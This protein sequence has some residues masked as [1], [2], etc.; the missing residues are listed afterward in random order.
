MKNLRL[1][2]W[3]NGLWPN[4]I[5]PIRYLLPYNKRFHN[6]AV[7]HDIQYWIWKNKKQSDY[8]FYRLCLWLSK[9]R[10]QKIF[11]KIYFILVDKFWFL[12]FK[13]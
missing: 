1:W 13:D 9:N 7:L 2:F 3:N 4:I 10:I 8:I 11:A 6:P 5:W 12:F